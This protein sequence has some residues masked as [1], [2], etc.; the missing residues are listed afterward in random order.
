MEERRDGYNHPL[1][2]HA[3][4][5]VCDIGKCQLMHYGRP[6]PDT[7]I[8]QVVDAS[9]NIKRVKLKYNGGIFAPVQI[10]NETP[11]EYDLRV[12]LTKLMKG[13]FG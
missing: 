5:K 12:L 13:G 4:R 6:D 2:Q 10:H 11:P 3:I 9:R 1:V 8:L 7:L